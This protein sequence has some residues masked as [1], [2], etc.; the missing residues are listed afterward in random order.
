MQTRGR[1]LDR[2][3]GSWADGFLSGFS[4]LLFEAGLVARS[5]GDYFSGGAPAPGRDWALARRQ[6]GVPDRARQQSGRGRA[7]AGP[8]R[9]RGGSHRRARGSN[10]SRTTPCR[11]SPTRSILRASPGRTAIGRSR[12]GESRS[13]G[14]PSSSRA[15]RAGARG[16]RASRS[17]LSTIPGEWLLDLPLLD[18]SYAAWS[19]ETLAASETPARDA[20]VGA[21]GARR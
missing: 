18:K 9:L 13:C 15:P 20:A 21:T 4:D 17:I 2:L 5:I 1:R 7:P 8:G 19:R 14:S 10:P 3:A 16:A 6:D 12:P 11:A